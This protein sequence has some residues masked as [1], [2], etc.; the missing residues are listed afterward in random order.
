MP[1]APTRPARISEQSPNFRYN[2]GNGALLSYNAADAQ[3]LFTLFGQGAGHAATV[4]GLAW[5]YVSGLT[6]HSAGDLWTD[7]GYNYLQ[8]GSGVGVSTAPVPEPASLALLGLGAFAL[9]RR[10]RT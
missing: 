3:A 4:E 7:N 9:L 10:R 8:L 6:G 1:A 2:V 5:Q